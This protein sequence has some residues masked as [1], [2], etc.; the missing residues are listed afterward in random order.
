MRGPTL[1]C[2]QGFNFL[3]WSVADHNADCH[4]E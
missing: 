3:K 1:F 2:E 4:E